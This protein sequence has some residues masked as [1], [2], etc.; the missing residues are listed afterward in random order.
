M[1]MNSDI[2][3][4]Y[5]REGQEAFGNGMKYSDCPYPNSS[6]ER[7][8]WESGFD[9]GGLSAQHREARKDNE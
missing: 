8:A 3:G 4:E 2:F 1:D 5:A 9:L 7:M 6:D